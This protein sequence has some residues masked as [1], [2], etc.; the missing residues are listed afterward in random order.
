MST[1]T[2]AMRRNGVLCEKSACPILSRKNCAKSPLLASLGVTPP[3]PALLI[4]E[5]ATVA[6]SAEEGGKI[7]W[8]SAILPI[9]G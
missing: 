9:Q 4:S 2:P 8:K 1:E 5:K 6:F 3:I 7:R